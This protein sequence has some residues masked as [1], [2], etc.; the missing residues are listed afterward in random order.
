MMVKTYTTFLLASVLHFA[1]IGTGSAQQIAGN[2]D[3]CI[4]GTVNA[5]KVTIT[6]SCQKSISVTSVPLNASGGFEKRIIEAVLMPGQSMSNVG[7]GT[8][9]PEGYVSDVAVTLENRLLLRAGNYKCV[10][11]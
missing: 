2:M 11:K 9:C 10:R 6:N 7:F 4:K 1:V 3:S 5:G 8:A